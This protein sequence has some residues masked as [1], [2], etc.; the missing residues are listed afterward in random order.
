MKHVF[1]LVGARPNFIKVAP[2]HRALAARGVSTTLVHTGQHY[3]PKMSDVFFKELGI[4]E[5]DVNLE[6]GPGDRLMQTKKI[7]DALVPLLTSK[8]PDALVVFGDVT[9]TAAG[10]MAGVVAGTRVVHVEAGLRSFNWKM[11][12][13]LNRM[14]ADHHADLLFVT[15]PAGV[16]NLKNESIPPERVHLVGNVMIDSLR[17]IESRAASSSVAATLGLAPHGYALL[18]LHRPE[19]V[20]D[21]ATLKDLWETIG[22]VCAK[23][24]VVYPY[25][26]RTKQRLEAAGLVAPTGMTMIEPVGY[27]DMIALVKNAAF[28]LTDS[29]GLQEET[30]ALG[31]PCLTLRDET[32]RPITVETGTSEIVGRDRAKI[33]DAVARA[34]SGAWKKGSLHPLWDG[35][36]AE[37]IA[38]ILLG[39]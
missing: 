4:P 26:V 2:L 20:D 8:R 35:H 25:H 11:P 36:A 23:I 27:T 33:L 31:V 39:S 21:P 16:E 9:S 15:E 3:D 34:M 7:V 19:S 12:E 17:A 24:P 30:S 22:A 32:E 1:L 6:I 18:T 29:G 13:E 37:R 14:I 38:V 28:V 10:A 5:P